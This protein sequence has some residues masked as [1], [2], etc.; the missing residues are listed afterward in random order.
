VLAEI[1]VTPS[2]HE[3]RLGH[4]DQPEVAQG[5]HQLDR[6]HRAVLDPVSG[7]HA[8]L[9]ER[10]HRDHEPDPADAVH[11]RVAAAAVSG[12]DAARKIV[13]EGQAMVGCE[14]LDRASGQ[15]G[16]SFGIQVEAAGHGH[17]QRELVSDD[18]VSE[19]GHG[20]RVNRRGQVGDAGDAARGQLP[21]DRGDI[22]GL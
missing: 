7:L 19:Q 22:Q 14:Q 6:D 20:R 3:R 8:D 13:G 12:R 18:V 2:G 21:A 9:L 10:R 1:A 4:D 15:F 16:G 5:A 11:G 17:V